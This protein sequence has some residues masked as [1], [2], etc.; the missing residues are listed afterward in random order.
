MVTQNNKQ[1]S[2]ATGGKVFVGDVVSD[3]MQKT[4]VV[5]IMRTLKHPLYDKVIR[6]YKKYSVHDEHSVAKIG[7][8][9]EIQECRPLSKNKHM[10]LV[11]VISKA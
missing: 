5:K 7:D 8:T 1:T 2:V 9:V 4:V 10:T 11:R 3:K 6:Q